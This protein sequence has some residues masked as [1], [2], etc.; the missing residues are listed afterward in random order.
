MA[1]NSS[2]PFQSSAEIDAAIPAAVAHLKAH[3]V[4]AY[5]TE[6][7]Y[8]FGTAI[9]EESVDALI[10][11]KGREK[12]KPFLLLVAGMDM[13]S[14]LV[15]MTPAAEA[16][17]AKFWPG[18]LTL[19]L[20]TVNECLPDP[21]RGANN[22]VA[23]RWTPHAGMQK[24]IKALGSAIT[25]TSANIADAPPAE[26]VREIAATWSDALDSGILLL[27]DGGELN[28]S[29]PS[30][31]IDCTTGSPRVVREGAISLAELQ[32][33]VPDLNLT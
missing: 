32:L 10:R 21:L 18:P 29:A 4:L 24:L 7:I 25:S 22:G 26:S 12:G 31:V 15:S 33:A 30:T 13:L 6:T 2:L 1:N 14:E 11:L 17:A 28:N 3:K 8:G 16:L 27:L 19:V 23:V 20:P 5:P 9:D